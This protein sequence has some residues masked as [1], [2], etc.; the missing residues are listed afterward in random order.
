MTDSPSDPNQDVRPARARRML[1]SLIDGAGLDAIGA[2]EQLPAKRVQA[3]V[4]EELGRRWVAPIADFAKIQIA[5]LENLYLVA[6]D[7]ILRG[8]V[9]AIDRALKIFDRLDRYHGFNRASPAIEPYGEEERER[10][11]AKLNEVAE[12]LSDEPQNG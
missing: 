9:A 4:R 11:I 2:E 6:M 10:L 7:G 5:R 8:E 3:I 1:A 12:R